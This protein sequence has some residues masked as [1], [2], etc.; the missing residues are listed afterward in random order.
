MPLTATSTAS[1]STTLTKILRGRC[2]RVCSFSARFPLGLISRFSSRFTGMV[3]KKASM[4]PSSNGDITP[5]STSR[6][7]PTTF[8]FCTAAL[9]T[10]PNRMSSITVRAGLS[11][12]FISLASPGFVSLYL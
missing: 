11:F 5:S 1:T 4:S 12:S 10:T 8:R 2:I 7:R 9:S 3:N 6:A